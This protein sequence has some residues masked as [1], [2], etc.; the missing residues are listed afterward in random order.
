MLFSRNNSIGID[1]YTSLT[2]VMPLSV[3]LQLFLYNS[4][5]RI[6]ILVVSINDKLFGLVHSSKL[7]GKRIV[8]I[9]RDVSTVVTPT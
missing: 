4:Y 7:K 9:K 1:P 3:D 6:L 8:G 2:T 5:K